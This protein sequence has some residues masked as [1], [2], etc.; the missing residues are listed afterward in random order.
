MIAHANRVVLSR[1]RKFLAAAVLA[2]SLDFTGQVASAQQS[3]QEVVQHGRELANLLC[4]RCHAISGPGPSP[5]KAAPPFST[6]IGKLTFEGLADQ[7]L[8]GLRLGHKPMP[9]WEFSERQALNLLVYIDSVSATPA[10]ASAKADRELQI[11]GEHQ[12][13]ALDYRTYCAS[14]HGSSAT[15]QGS[16]SKELKVPAPSLVDLRQRYDGEFPRSRL[17]KIID[18]SIEKFRHRQRDMPLMGEWFAFLAKHRDNQ[19]DSTSRKSARQRIHALL[20]YLE[21]LQK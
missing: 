11:A 4:K 12:D 9:P 18:G 6:L 19:S 13:A 15:G 20:D 8:E 1:R 7:L 2:I 21:S 5:R 16:F 14:C 10:A 3:E 17:F